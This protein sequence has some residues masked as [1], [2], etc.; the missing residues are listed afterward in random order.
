MISLILARLFAS[1]LG[2]SQQGIVCWTE[3]PTGAEACFVG[4]AS[5]EHTVAGVEFRHNQDGTLSLV[6]NAW[7]Y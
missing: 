6:V 1:A 4:V 3:P 5:T 2:V 7:E